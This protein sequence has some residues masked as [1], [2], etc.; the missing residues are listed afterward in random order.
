[1]ELPV[2]ESAALEIVSEA[3]LAAPEA[4]SVTDPRTPLPSDW[5]LSAPE[6]VESPRLWV[7]DF[8]WSDTIC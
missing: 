4:V 2:R 8:S 5:P 1:M 7:A 6:R 3:E